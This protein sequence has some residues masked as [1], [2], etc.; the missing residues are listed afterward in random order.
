VGL[1]AVVVVVVGMYPVCTHGAYASL[2][3]ALG[4]GHRAGAFYI[5]PWILS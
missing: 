3:R 4:G 1:Y 5:Y 2:G